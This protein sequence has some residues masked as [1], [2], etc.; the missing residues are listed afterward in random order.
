MNICGD[1]LFPSGGLYAVV[2]GGGEGIFATRHDGT[3]ILPAGEERSGIPINRAGKG[4]KVWKTE[5]SDCVFCGIPLP[6]N[7]TYL[8][9]L[10]QMVD[11]L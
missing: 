2:S 6:D 4:W 10:T 1:I 9:F 8:V 3:F 5:G 7:R 11:A